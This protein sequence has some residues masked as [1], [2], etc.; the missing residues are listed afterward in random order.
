LSQTEFDLLRV[1]LTNPNQN[2]SRQ[3]IL[4]AVWNDAQV[5]ERAVDAHI[6]QLRQKLIGFN[7]SIKSLYGRGYILS[8]LNRN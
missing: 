8:P 4:K 2:I 6:S 3:E 1:F 7:H 5:T